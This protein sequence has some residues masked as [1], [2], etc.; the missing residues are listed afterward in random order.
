MSYKVLIVDD[1]PDVLTLAELT[2]KELRPHWIFVTESDPVQAVGRLENEIFDAVISDFQMPQMNGSEFLGRVALAQPLSVRLLVSS[3]LERGMSTE[4]IGVAHRFFAKPCKYSDV[5]QAI[6]R[7]IG[8]RERLRSSTLRRLLTKM[9]KLPSPPD[10]Y[11][12]I[13]KLLEDDSFHVQALMKL[14]QREVTVSAAVLKMANS[15]FFGAR[16]KIDSLERAVNLLGA[17]TIKS[18]ALGAELFSRIEPAKAKQFK[19]QQ[20]FEHSVRVASEAARLVEARGADRATRDLAYTAGLLHDIG[21]LVLVQV[22][23]REYARVVERVGTEF[24]S[25]YQSEIK[26]FGVSHQ[27]VGAYV[28]SLWNLPEQIVEAVAYHHDPTFAPAREVSVLTYV[29]AANLVDRGLPE[30]F[31]ADDQSDEVSYLSGLGVRRE[32]LVC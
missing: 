7:S 17:Q 13:Q 30:T 10:T 2:L 9:T 18:L 6:E 14:L 25:L 4:G 5:V 22:I 24:P 32:E 3:N 20:L 31:A 8:L 16:Y 1:S 26:A 27:E 29:V 15:S 28:L 21:K 19:I 12:A 11:M 23:P